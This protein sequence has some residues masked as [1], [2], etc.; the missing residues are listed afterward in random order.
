[1][2]GLRR[3]PRRSGRLGSKGVREEGPERPILDR[4]RARVVGPDRR[5]GRPFL[6]KAEEAAHQGVHSA[7]DLG[8]APV[9]E[10]L[11][12][13][14]AER[15]GPAVRMEDYCHAVEHSLELQVVFLQHL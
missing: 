4:A 1:M 7:G 3:P 9:H 10:G 6:D 5:Q 14:L 12:D 8:E 11:V 13:W 15:G 2:D